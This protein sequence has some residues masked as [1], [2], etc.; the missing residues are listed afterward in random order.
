MSQL[1]RSVYQFTNVQSYV[2]FCTLTI[3]K[4]MAT[5]FSFECTFPISNNHYLSLKVVFSIVLA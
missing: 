1:G 2:N 3:S 4:L 5:V